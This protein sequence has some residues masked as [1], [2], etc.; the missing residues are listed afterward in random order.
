MQWYLR[1]REYT[2]FTYPLSDVNRTQ[3]SWWLAEVADAPVERMREFMGELEND[4]D[5]R[6]HVRRRTHQGGWSR[7]SDPEVHFGRRL[8][9]YA[10]VRALRPEVV[11]ET[12]TDKGLGSIVLAAAI[13]RNEVG[14]LV[15]I[16]VHADTGFLITEP[17][18]E[19]VDRRI[20]DSLDVLNN[21][22]SSVDMFLHDS[23]HTPEHEVAEF[24]AVQRWL[25]PTAVVLS[26]NAHVTDVLAG[27]AERTGRRYAY[28]QER[29]EHHWYR[30]GG[31]G[32]ARSNSR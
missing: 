18:D 7:Y 19:V 15:T 30:G 16:D 28:F 2:N 8:G 26:D 10:L 21:L 24:E 32:L 17:Y 5:I 29:P 3:L 31:I 9:W 14:R 1:S 22:G 13:L 6:D 25:A 27:W 11:V 20:G 23:L 12:G 4:R